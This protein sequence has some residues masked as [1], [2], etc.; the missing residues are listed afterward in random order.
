LSWLW[1][2][3]R[4]DEG[5]ALECRARGPRPYV[6]VPERK[7][8]I[9][10]HCLTEVHNRCVVLQPGRVFCVVNHRVVAAQ[11][12]FSARFVK[13]Q[14]H[15]LVLLVAGFV[16][17]GAGEKLHKNHTAIGRERKP[18]DKISERWSRWSGFICLVFSYLV[19]FFFLV[20]RC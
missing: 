9:W 8:K 15:S 16:H 2:G 5:A 10:L 19:A 18:F 13:N 17:D 14:C 6:C 4:R 7:K 3:S 11:L 12:D 20:I 1:K